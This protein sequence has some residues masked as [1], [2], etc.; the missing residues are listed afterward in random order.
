MM[1]SN[2]QKDKWIQ[3]NNFILNNIPENIMILD[4][5]G[6]VRFISDYCKSFMEDCN[7]A[8]EKT[9]EFFKKIQNLHQQQQQNELG[10]SFRVIDREIIF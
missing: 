3:V 2:V 5:K 4:F 10:P 1:W 9:K 8:L 6:E 7:F